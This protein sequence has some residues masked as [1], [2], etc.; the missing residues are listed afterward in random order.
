[1]KHTAFHIKDDAKQQAES[2]HN[3][4]AGLDGIKSIRID[5][6]ANTVTVEYDDDEISQSKIESALRNKNYI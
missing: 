5:S 2:I 1:M 3:T 4:I 6:F